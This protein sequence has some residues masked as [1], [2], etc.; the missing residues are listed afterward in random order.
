M[1][2]GFNESVWDDNPSYI[3]DYRGQNHV[4]GYANMRD[5][6]REIRP[7]MF[8]GIGTWGW[9]REMQRQPA[10]F[11]LRGPKNPAAPEIFEEETEI[12]FREF[13]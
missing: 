2:V 9:T 6:I 8:L 4:Q 11:I 1:I 10:P 7:G 3:L 13:S 12:T 5:E